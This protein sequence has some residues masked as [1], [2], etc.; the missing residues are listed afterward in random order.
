MKRLVFKVEM[1]VDDDKDT[2]RIF[3]ALYAAGCI[4]MCEGGELDVTMDE[5]D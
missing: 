4:S 3:D 1:D 2:D 5:D